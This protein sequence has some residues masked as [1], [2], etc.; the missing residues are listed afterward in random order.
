MQFNLKKYPFFNKISEEKE[1]RNSTEL[2]NNK[3]RIVKLNLPEI[4]TELNNSN[5]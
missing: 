4:I 5:I 2:L 3:E 1:N